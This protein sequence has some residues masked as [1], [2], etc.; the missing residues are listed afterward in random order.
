MCVFSLGLLVGRSIGPLGLCVLAL[1]G[2]LGVAAQADGGSLS[3]DDYDVV[4][5][6]AG[7][8]VTK[9]VGTVFLGNGERAEEVWVNVTWNDGKAEW[10]QGSWNSRT[11]QWQIAITWPAGR[12][13]PYSIRPGMYYRNRSGARAWYVYPST[14]AVYGD[15]R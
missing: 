5:P 15:P 2:V 6:R 8:R 10:R 13:A 9:A 3:V 7:V 4:Y 14:Y 1:A 12:R 11:R